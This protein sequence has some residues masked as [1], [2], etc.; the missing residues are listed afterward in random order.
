MSQTNSSVRVRPAGRE[1]TPGRP[2]RRPRWASPAY[3]FLLPGM[4]ILG[5][6]V[7]Y[8]A[9]QA[10]VMSLEDWSLRPDVPSEFVGL[11]NYAAAIQ[12]PVFW[13]AMANAAIYLLATVPPQLFLGLILAAAL[14]K[15]FAGRTFF[16]AVIY[17]PVITSW[18]VVSILF[19]YL[20]ATDNGL[21]NFLLVDVTGWL[22]T[23]ID[24]FNDRWSALFVI[25]LLGT[26][27]G[28]G[29][30]MLILLAALQSVP[31]DLYEAAEMDGAGPIRQFWSITMPGI[32]RTL[33]FVTIL[34][35]IGAFNVFISVKL[36]TDGG[37]A[38]LTEVPLTYLYKEAFSYLDFGY[39]SALAFLLTAVVFVLSIIQFRLNQRSSEDAAA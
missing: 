31:H 3:L 20:F 35:V 7:V 28:V 32:R 25:S 16:R 2:R 17:I 14:N 5:L 19:K 10:A 22:Q 23:N 37:P 39:G 4:A 8:P 11:A 13:R 18:V 36:I 24:W 33:N 27:K 15:A 38:S 30:S 21:V 29:W 26:W 9:V 6:I 34:L 1:H 12:D